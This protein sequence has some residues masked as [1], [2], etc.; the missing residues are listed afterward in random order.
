MCLKVAQHKGFSDVGAE[1]IWKIFAKSR[2]KI[3]RNFAKSLQKLIDFRAKMRQ[4]MRG[5]SECLASVPKKFRKTSERLNVY[6][7]KV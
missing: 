6:P 7:V 5:F 4:K 1:E 3:S 2:V